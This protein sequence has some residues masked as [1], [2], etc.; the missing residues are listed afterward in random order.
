M[1]GENHQ[2]TWPDAPVPQ[3]WTTTRTAEFV[4]HPHPPATP[5]RPHFGLGHCYQHDWHTH[6][7]SMSSAMTGS[8]TSLSTYVHTT[9]RPM[10]EQPLAMRLPLGQMPTVPHLPDN[11]HEHQYPHCV[12]DKGRN[13][14]TTL[15][16]PLAP[17]IGGVPIPKPTSSLR[18]P[19]TASRPYTC[20]PSMLC[21]ARIEIVGSF[22]QSKRPHRRL[23]SSTCW[24]ISGEPKEPC[25]WS[26]DKNRQRYWCRPE[27]QW[28]SDPQCSR[29]PSRSS[30]L[31]TA[32]LMR[33]FKVILVTMLI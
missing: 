29:R 28:K 20:A 23:M 11:N 15:S 24:N 14:W 33:R 3:S 19:P 26:K 8:A 4:S 17:G 22:S 1:E 7:C 30:G 21:R 18:S 16:K 6:L 12:V 32:A 27:I 5:E 31:S 25:L 13:D 10:L 9:I 2:L